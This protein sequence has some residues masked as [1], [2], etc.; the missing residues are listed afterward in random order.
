[1]V[2][3]CC[4]YQHE[5]AVIFG[6][7]VAIYR[8]RNKTFLLY[9]YFIRTISKVN[10]L[11]TINIHEKKSVLHTKFFLGWEREFPHTNFLICTLPFNRFRKCV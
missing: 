4:Y 9:A 7:V 2:F 5:K 1:M 3:S 10:T 8:R 6:I 11:T